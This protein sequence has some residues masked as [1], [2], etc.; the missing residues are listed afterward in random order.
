MNMNLIKIFI[1][2]ILILTVSIFPF[3]FLNF[4]GN[5]FYYIIFTLVS[6]FS[7]CY[8]FRYRSISFESFLALLFWL[9][10][11]LNLVFKFRFLTACFLRV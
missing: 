6:L 7:F 3:G 10:F 4:E 11:G 2:I 8:S 5:K 9:G 1:S